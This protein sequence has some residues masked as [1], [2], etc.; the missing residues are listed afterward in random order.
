MKNQQML[1][2]AAS[3][4]NG[5]MNYEILRAY[6]EPLCSL[7]AC[8]WLIMISFVEELDL[9]IRQSSKYIGTLGHI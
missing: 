5:N 3:I 8:Y 9:I 2:R 1:A 6:Y 4:L 7:D